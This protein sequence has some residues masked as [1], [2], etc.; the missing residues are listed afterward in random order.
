MFRSFVRLGPVFLVLAA[1]AALFGF[2]A[3]TGDVGDVAQALSVLFL[4]LAALSLV[5]GRVLRDRDAARRVAAW[6]R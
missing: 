2:G 4:A 1:V 5:G 6:T 3:F